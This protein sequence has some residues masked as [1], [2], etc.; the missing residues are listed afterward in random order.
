MLNQIKNLLHASKKE[1]VAIKDPTT[2]SLIKILNKSE[3]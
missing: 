3:I 1:I 2:I